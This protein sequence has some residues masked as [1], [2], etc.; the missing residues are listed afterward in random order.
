MPAQDRKHIGMIG[1]LPVRAPR[2]SRQV[3][4]P[5]W[6][7]ILCIAACGD[8]MDT[9]C[10]T[11]QVLYSGIFAT[12]RL[13]GCNTTTQ[14]QQMPYSAETGPTRLRR[15]CAP[16]CTRWKQKIPTLRARVFTAADK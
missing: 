4:Y 11:S 9:G 12:E 7:S 10:S 8:A 6:T 15:K 5:D 3:R 2:T 14:L 13:S 1:P 16:K